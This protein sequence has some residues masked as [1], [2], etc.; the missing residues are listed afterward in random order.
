MLGHQLVDPRLVDADADA[1]RLLL[2]ADHLREVEGAGDEEQ[3]S[4][5]QEAPLPGVD[6]QV[7]RADEQAAGGDREGDR[8]LDEEGGSGLG[9]LAMVFMLTACRPRGCG[10]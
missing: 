7:E 10:E 6:G 4:D 9:V 2:V 3:G 1:V 5:E 8:G